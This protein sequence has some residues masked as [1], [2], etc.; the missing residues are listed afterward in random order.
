MASTRIWLELSSDDS[1]MHKEDIA[2]AKHEGA[3]LVRFIPGFSDTKE[4]KETRKN[5]QDEKTKMSLVLSGH[6]SREKMG[7][8]LLDHKQLLQKLF[9]EEKLPPEETGEFILRGCMIGLGSSHKETFFYKFA[10]K[11][12]EDSKNHHIKVRALTSWGA[13][14]AR[15]I[16]WM[17]IRSDH[18]GVWVSI[19]R[20]SN[21]DAFQKDMANY[22][23]HH[24][25][26]FFF[27]SKYE[28]T[29]YASSNE[30]RKTLDHPNFTLTPDVMK[31]IRPF[32]DERFRAWAYA[33]TRIS[34]SSSSN[35]KLG[36][37]IFK[38]KIEDMKNNFADLQKQ[39]P[40]FFVRMANEKQE[41]L[42]RPFDHYPREYF[43]IAI[44]HELVDEIKTFNP[45]LE[46]DYKCAL[47]YAMEK[48]HSG[49]VEALIDCGADPLHK[50]LIYDAPLTFALNIPN[51]RFVIKMLL[52]IHEQNHLD[53]IDE[54]DMTA[55]MRYRD[56]LLAEHRLRPA[57]PDYVDEMLEKMALDDVL[58][59]ITVQYNRTH[60]PSSAKHEPLKKSTVETCE[61]YSRE[62]KAHP[63]KFVKELM[64]NDKDYQRKVL[65]LL[66]L[67]TLS[68]LMDK[69]PAERK[70]LLFE[71][72]L[73]SGIDHRKDPALFGCMLIKTPNLETLL[74]E[75]REAILNMKSEIL[76]AC[77]KTSGSFFADTKTLKKLIMAAFDM[78][79][80][81]KAPKNK[82]Q[83]KG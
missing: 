46:F 51:L 57:D 30:L 38:S 78:L 58:E 19:I 71:V 59:K 55:I 62:A 15:D 42:P 69:L 64:E 20:K 48:G 24:D 65:K 31:I 22:K 35:E 18:T 5:A 9:V 6:A 53:K 82:I 73:D 7:E 12:F 72:F 4:F 33:N 28:E 21:A 60:P 49:V 2:L 40:S 70:K 8:E 75:K 36:F 17:M 25:I 10:E 79:E 44:D 34:K 83:P 26:T 45:N 27:T 61:K 39:Y 74:P 3:H 16:H 47:L 52:Q 76:N 23:S 68:F 81:L 14:T 37:T 32:D 77:E 50:D 13:T 1:T 80:Q 41:I 67:E 29:V 56:E 66:D 11:L 54:K 43:K 63:Q